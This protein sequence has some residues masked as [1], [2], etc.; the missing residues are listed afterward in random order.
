M[1]D[2]LLAE[3]SQG[4]FLEAAQAPGLAHVGVG[5]AGD[6]VTVVGI[7]PDEAVHALHHHLAQLGWHLVQAVQEDQDRL[8]P[9]P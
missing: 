5:P 4:H 6:Q 3:G 1:L 8:L 7:A 2:L 9:L